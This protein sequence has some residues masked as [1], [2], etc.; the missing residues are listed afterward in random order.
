MEDVSATQNILVTLGLGLTYVLLLVAVS[1]ILFYSIREIF[2][3]RKANGK[4]FIMAGIL[5]GLFLIGWLISPYDFKW[6]Q[7]DKG[8]TPTNSGIIGGALITVYFLLGIALATVAFFE[9]KRLL[10]KN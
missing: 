7:A 3:N 2:N 9:V 1:A 10:D 5:V 6:T 8:V 4:F